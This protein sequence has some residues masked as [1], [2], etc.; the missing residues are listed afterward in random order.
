[1]GEGR[2][3]INMTAKSEDEI[4]LEIKDNGMGVPPDIDLSTVDSLGLHLVRLLSEDQLKENWSGTTIREPELPSV[5]N[6][7]PS[8]FTINW[9]DAPRRMQLGT[10]PPEGECAR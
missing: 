8:R 10:A 1:M 4:L 2:I 3:E 5:F 9:I 7:N 6:G